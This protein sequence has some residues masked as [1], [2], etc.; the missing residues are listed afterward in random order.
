M[1]I[2]EI[3][4]KVFS[5]K[6][7]TLQILPRH[8]FDILSVFLLNFVFEEDRPVRHNGWYTGLEG[9]FLGSLL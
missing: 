8:V 1:Q 2:V 3:G 6:V 4:N 9:L 7:S 5:L